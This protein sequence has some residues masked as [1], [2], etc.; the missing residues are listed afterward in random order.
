V[1]VAKA[2]RSRLE[3][4][5]TPAHGLK[6]VHYDGLLRFPVADGTSES[7]PEE[8][9]EAKAP[10]GTPTIT[11]NALETSAWHRDRGDSASRDNES[12]STVGAQSEEQKNNSDP[13]D[14]AEPDYW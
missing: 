9:R 11:S 2:R 6:E 13:G 12:E 1:L 10:L 4:A 7:L 8:A 3:D 14:N 5:R